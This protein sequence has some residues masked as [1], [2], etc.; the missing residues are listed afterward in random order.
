MAK[1]HR[2][3]EP[4]APHSRSDRVILVR[5]RWYITTR[6]RVDVGPYDSKEAA[7]YAAAQLAI[8]LDG[9]DDPQIALAFIAEFNRRRTQI[10]R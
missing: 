8:V 7:D 3:G 4:P 6:E 1:G 5:G 2:K 10:G 9:V